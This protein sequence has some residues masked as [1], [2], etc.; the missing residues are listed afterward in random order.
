MASVMGLLE[1][2]EAVA[3]VRVEELQVGLVS[4]QI[5]YWREALADA[6]EELALP[7]D[8]P[9][10]AVA[11]HRSLTAEV[12]VPAEV[13]A[14]LAELARAEGVSLFMV[15]QSAL[16]VLLSRLGAG[17]DVPIGT[18]VAGRTDVA[19]DDLVGFFVNT[20]V[21]RADLSGDPTFRE[22]LDRM[23]ETSLSAFDHQEVPFEKL[24]EELAP[25]RSR[26]RH[27]LFQTV[28]TLQNNA[29]AALDLP[30][31]EASA[32]SAGAPP[33][34]FDLDLVLG[35]TFDVQGAPAGVHGT[36]AGAA[37][38]FEPESVERIAVHFLRVLA[39]V[40]A[41]PQIRLSGV[42]LLDAAERRR[43]LVEWNDTAVAVEPTTLPE[44]FEAQVART[45]DAVAVVADGVEL[46]FA[47]LDARANRLAR[48]LAGRGV[49]PESV[50][51]V[52]LERGTDMLVSLLAVMK[53]G[54]AYL[55]VDPAYPV[56][57]IE[58][59]L[60]DAAPVAVV[61]SR[62]V[63]DTMPSGLPAV[64]LD[65][66]AVLAEL[67][68]LADTSPGVEVLPEHPAYV[69]FTSGSTGRPKGVAVTHSGLANYVSSVPGRVGFDAPGVRYALLQAQ[70]TDL[71]NTVVFASLT[72]GGVLHVIDEGLVTDPSAVSA[73]LAEHGIDCVKIVP[74]HLAALS[75]VVG[76]EGVLPTRSLVLGG[77]AASPA[78]VRELVE[79]AGDRGVFNHYGPTETTIG[80]ATTRLEADGSLVPVGTPVANTR[81]YVLDDA[82]RPVPQGVAGELYVA[83][84]QLAR[85]YVRRPGLTAERFVA[86]P[87]EPGARMYRTGD[88]A[89][90]TADGKVVFLGRADE[91]VKVRGF[92]V[93]PAEV[94]AVIAGHP[95]VAQTVVAAREDVPGDVRLVAYVVPV[96]EAGA[97]E[98]LPNAVREFTARRLPEHMV[99][100]AVVLLDA[101][102]L[103]GNGKLD[104]KALP[105][106]VYATGAGRGPV[107]AREEILCAAFAEVLGLENVGVDDDF[108]RL[109]GHSLLAVHL[110]EVLRKQGV[111]VS[112]R[113]LFDT[114]TPAGLAASAGAE[115]VAVPANLIPAD[116]REITPDMLPLVDLTG[117]EISRIAATVEGGCAN[118]AD[119]YP[120]APLQEGLL[121]HHLMAEGGEDAYLMPVVVEMD[122]RERV[123]D[124]ARA[125]QQV[126]DRHDILR[127]SFVWEGLR[128][129][130]QVVWRRAVLPVTEVALDP[131]AADPVAELQA[132]VG[133]SMDLGRAP[134]ISVHAA[135]LPEGGRWLV[136]LRLHHL[137]QDHTALEV[138]LHEV[139]AFLAG[140]GGELPQ[141]LPFRDFV[142]Q[143][144]G[145]ADRVA[146]ERYF[147]ELLGDVTE[148]TAPYEL[149]DVHGDG[150]AVER[151]VVPLATGLVDRLRSVARRA[152]TSPATLMHVA[153][154]RVLGA[155]S[156]HADVVFGT[157]LFGRMNAGAGADRVAGM[158]LNT[159]PVRLKTGELGALEAVTATRGQLAELL[160]HEHASLALAQ[161]ASGLPGNTPVFTSLLNYRH[162][163]GAEAE[164]QG[165]TVPEGMRV[166]SSS[167]RTNYPLT[168]SVDD[169]GDTMALVVDAVAP[170]A[171]ESVGLLVRTAV[172]GLV[173]LVETAL[174]GA[175]DEALRDVPVLATEE[176]H[177]ILTEWNDA[178][179]ESPGTTLPAL[180]EAQA[181]QTPDAV[182]IV[183]DG[184]RVS[185]AELEA[186]ANRLAR[187]LVS[188]GVGAE[189]VVG[190]CLERGVELI[191]ALLAV[192]KAGGAYLPI[193]PA[194]PADRVAFT[195][196]DA[197][198]ALVLTE[199]GA[200]DRLSG[201]GVDVVALDDPAVAEELALLSAGVL[202]TDERGDLA[203][204]Q[205]AYVIYTSGSTG[206]PKGVVVTHRN[207]TDLFARTQGLFGFGPADV[208]SWF[209]SFAFDFSVW[210]LWGA[211]L[212][213]G[214]VAVVSY[215][216]SR[217]PED[218]VAL[219][220]REGVTMLSQTPS[221]FYQ[222]MGA[223][224]RRPEAVRS[225]RAVVF[226]G[227][228]LD[229]VRLAGWWE[230]HGA[231]GPRLVNMYGITETTVHVTFQELAAG[232]AAGS[233]VGRGI[234]GLGVFVLDERLR[235]VPVGVGGEVYVTGGQLARGY[236]GR[237]GLSA[238]RF[239]ASPFGAA[240]ERMYRTGDRARWGADGLLEYLGRADEQV[241]VRGFRIEPG[242][243]GSVVAEHPGVA[244]AAVVARQD[245][246]D[247]R[248]VAYV[249]PAD[250]HDGDELPSITHEFLTARLPEHMVPSAI[251][252]LDGLPLT[253]NGKLDRKALPAPEYT[254]SAG[255]GP[256]NAREEVLCAAFAEVLGL[257][258]VGVEDNFFQLG[259]HSL[260]AVRLVE[261]L[262][263]HGVSVSVRA[264]FQSPTP[265]GLAASTGATQVEVPANL[266]PADAVEITPEMLPLVELTADEIAGVVAT[267]QGGAA[268]VADVYPLAPL[269]QGLWFHHL[270]AEGGVDA[271]VLP[272]VLEFASRTRL[273]AFVE[274]LQRV[275]DRHDIF[276]TS[277]VWKGLVEP[278]QVVWRKAVLPVAEVALDPQAGDQVEQLLAL[279]GLSVDLGRAPLIDI[280]V[281]AVP[282]GDSWLALMRVHHIVQ[283][284]TAVEVLLREVEAFLTGRGDTLP[285]PLPFRTFV[286]Q[287]RGGVAQ[288]EHER[289][290]ADLLDD[291]E[292]PTA[293]FGLVD[294]RGDGAAAVRR[295]VPFP[296][297]LHER[298]REVSRRLGTSAATVLHVAWA[299]VLAA[300]SSRDDVV[301]GTVLFGRMNSGEGSAQVLGPFINTLPVRVRT[302]ELSVLGA[303]TGMRAQLAD[304]LEH[305]HASLALAQQASGVA[306]DTP[307]FTSFLN[308]RHNTAPSAARASA[309]GLAGIRQVYARERTNY[310]LSVSVNDTGESIALDVDAV[311]PVDPEAVGVLL[312]TATEQLVGALETALATG[313]D[314][315]LNTLP[316]LAEEELRRV[317][318]EWNDTA[319]EV[320][321]VPVVG[322]FEQWAAR[323]PDAVAVVADGEEVSYAELDAR[324]N[325]LA[326]R[327]AGR[328]VGPESVVA[329]ALE[330][331]VDLVV[332]VLA[333]LKSGAAHLP[334]DPEYPAER[335]AFMLEDACPALVL[336][337]AATAEV[338]ERAGTPVLLVDSAEVLRE[339][340]APAERPAALPGQL[341]YVIYTSGSTGR[342]KGVGVPL[343]AFA[344][345]V[346]A[347]ARFG[348]GPGSRVAQFAS[349]SFDNFCLEWS[350]A[351]TYGATLVVVPPNR[352]LGAELAGFFTEAGVTHATLPP[353][354]LAAL[355][356]G[357]IGAEV[358]LEVGGEACPP[359]LVERWAAGRRLFNTYG[360]TETTVD[361]LSWQARPGVTDVPIGA[362][363]AN[364]RAYVLDGAL[365]PVPSGAAGELYLAG[366]GLARGYLGRAG[367]TAERF[368]ADPFGGAG[369]RLYRTGDLVRRNARGEMEYLGRADDQVKVRGF[370]IELGEVRA[371]VAAHPQVLQAAVV[372]RGEE[373]GDALLVAYVV[374]AQG[375]VGLPA[376]V[377]DFVAERLPGYMVPSAVVVLDALPLTVNGK[378]DHRALPAPQYAAG[379]GRGPAT[380]Q[381]E[382]L[383]GV[384]AQ[385][386]GLPEVGVD[387]DFFALGGHSLLATRLMSRIRTV[388][389][390]EVP[391]RTLF[392]APT[393][394]GLAARLGDAGTARTALT[395]GERPERVPLSYGQ[396]RVWFLGQLEG[397]SATYNVPVALRLVGRLEEEALNAALLDV[398]GRHEVLRTVFPVVDDE[399]YQ[400][401]LP[402]EG[403]A[404]RLSVAEVAAEELEPAI[405]EAAAHLFDLASELPI[406]ASLFRTA[407]EEH[408]L[409]VTIHHIASDGWST[410]VLA[411]DLSVAYAAR[412]AGRAPQ[413]QPLPVQYA[414]YALWQRGLLGDEHDP[415]SMISRQA[416]YWRGAL[417][418][419]PEK[420]DLSF[421]R[422]RPAVPSHRGHQV[423]VAVPAEVHARLVELARA[424]GVT[425]FMVLQGA[426]AVLLSR[427]GAGTD[428]PIGSPHAGRTD[429]AL[430]DLVGFFLNTLVV[431][432]DLSGDPTF[433]QVLG[434]VRERSLEAFT[435]QDVPFERLVEE[436]APNRSMAHHALF[437]VMLTLQNTEQAVLELPGLRVEQRRAGRTP[438]R[439]DLDVIV[440]ESF[441]EQGAPAGVRGSVTAA[442]DL[443]DE[444][445]A[446][447]LV[448]RL[449]HVLDVLTGDPQIR[450]STVDVL[451]AAERGRLLEEWNATAADVPSGTVAELFAAQVARDPAAVAV[452]A[453]DDEE[454]TYAELDA[455]ANSLARYLVGRGVG[456]ESIVGVCL[457]RGVDL[458][459]ALLAVAKA[460]GAYL[461]IDP[462]YPV[463]RIAYM[464]EDAEPAV[465]LASSGTAPVVPGSAVLVDA[466]E[467]T[468]AD[469][470]A[471]AAPSVR[472]ENPAYVIYTSGSTGRPKGVLVSH[473]GVASLVAGH[474][475]RLGVGAGSRVGQFASPG[476][477][478]FGWEW[479]MAL[480]TGAT[481]VVIPQERRLGEALPQFLAAERVTHVTLPPAV[482]ATLDEQSIGAD[483]VLVTAGEACPPDVMARWARGHRLFNSYGPTETTVDAT[484]WRCDPQAG[485][486]AIGAPVVNTRVFVLDEFLA[487]VP[488]G[489]PGELYVAG[490]GLA[491][492]YLG[493]PG[494]TA[495][496][497]V[498]NP[499]GGPGERF[500]RTGDRARWT[501]DGQ[502]VFAGRTDDQ[503]K[504]R[505]FRIEPG[506]IENVIASH[507]QVAQAAVVVR[508]DTPAEKRLVAYVVADGAPADLPGLVT[509]LAAERLPEYMVPSAV[510]LL[511]ALPITVNGK[512]DR[513]ALPAPEERPAVG[514]GPAN[515][516]EELLC[517][518]FAQILGVE[519]VGVDDDFF[520]LGGHSLLAVRLASRIRAVLGVN[521]D[522]RVLFDAPTV[523]ALAA[524]IADEDGN[525][526]PALMPMER[527]DRVPLSYAQR[528]MWFIGQLQ[529]A[530]AAYNVP[531]ALK[532]PE[533]IDRQALGAA[534]RDVLGRHEVLR[535]VLPTENGEPHQRIIPL[536][537][538][539]WELSVVEV[540]PK[541][542][543]G[544]VA[545]VAGHVFD[546][547][548]EVPIRAWLLEAG[549][550]ER[551]LAV[552]V[553]H[554]AGDGW[555][556]APLARD[557]SVAYAAR[558]GGRMPLWEP[559]PVQ[560]AD[561]ALWQREL[562][563]EAG[564][565]K[566]LLWRQMEYWRAEL[567]GVPEE[568]ALPVDRVRPAVAS[569]R[570]HEVRVEV[571]AV[572]HAEL[573]RVARAEGVTMFMVLQ[574]ALAVLLSRLGAGADVPIGA[575][576]AGR[577]DAALED[578]VGFFVNTLVIRAD[579]SGDP[580]F[581]EVLGRVRET[582]LSA[583]EHQD[584]PFERL[585]EELA[586][587]R[588]MGRHPLFQTVFTMQNNARA[589]LDLPGTGVSGM[590]TGAATAARFDLDVL[591]GEAF[592][593]Q[594]APAGVF[595]T[596]IG[597]ADLFEAESV[598]RIAE[599]LVRVL[600]LVAGDPGLRLSGVDVLEETERRRVLA[601]WNDTGVDFGA[602][603]VPELFAVQAVRTPD[604][605]AV[606]ADG[607]EVSYRELDERANRLAHY[608]LAQGVGAESL[609]GICLPRGVDMMVALLATWKAGAGYL[610]VD[611]E[612]PAERIAFM[613]AD[614][615]AVLTLTDEEVLDELPA[616]RARVVA[617]DGAL[618]ATQVAALPTTAPGVPVSADGLAYVIYT[619]GSTGRPKGV[620]VTHGGL[621]NYARHAAGSYGAEGGA[622]LHS[623]LAF[624][625]T[626]TSVVVPLISGAPVVV[627]REGG[628]EGLAQLLRD[629]GGFGLVKAVPAHLPLLGEMLSDGQAKGAAA[630]WVVGGEALPAAVVRSWLE[631]AP[632]SVVVNEYGPTET[633]VGC[634]VFALRA[635]QEMGEPVPVGRPIA[636]TRLYVLDAYLRP[637]A[638]G[639]A[640]ELYIAGTQLARGYVKRP[641][642]TAER[643]VANPFEPALRMYR[644]GDVA[645]WRTDGQL[646]YLGRADEQV[647][648]RGFRIEPGE[649]QAVLAAHPQVA[650]A[651]VI[652]RQDVPGDTRLVA[653]VVAD[654][655][656]GGLP[657][658]VLAF[659]AK[660]LPEY[661]VPS[662]V[663][664]LDALPLTGNGK[665]DRKALPV[666]DYAAG[667][668]AGRAPANPQEQLLCQAF[669]AVLGLEKVGVDDDFFELGGH[670]L[671][672]VELVARIRAV[673]EVEV[674]IRTLFD[675]PT[676]AGLAQRLG[677]EKSS[678][679][680]LRP[681]RDRDAR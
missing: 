80:V 278:V 210:E 193:D 95:L 651:A 127:T 510:V 585:V 458:M 634:A 152:G 177:R 225:L 451:D 680:A 394:A 45:P 124:F 233:V 443:L 139:R 187:S 501:A 562:L 659:A 73:H 616:G 268:N 580:S 584:V 250:G 3:R 352:R 19:L 367:L 389:G 44:L 563:G 16:A 676:V 96:G 157:V 311:A 495:E 494:L 174:D 523:A 416:D 533:Q 505:G 518:V 69:I 321:P 255:R 546:L 154:A 355:E 600:E 547:A 223:E 537:E 13:H 138:L 144:R 579:L 305:E 153:W 507:P 432:T 467:T 320:S 328:G 17:T 26:G 310:P 240:G 273:D 524:R 185:Y 639:V 556:W 592:D 92:R 461:P 561:Y 438:A 104:R 284:H 77:E 190:V 271:Y 516:R 58:I 339:P 281:A 161:Q 279:A 48:L 79:H 629:G 434:R 377:R 514:R 146:H 123:E 557:L 149:V 257:E 593:A 374:A 76:V 571:P 207:V 454:V 455:R 482:L 182:A 390:V 117:E 206:R 402:A 500:Y 330:R 424:E 280:H 179:A 136:L 103:T 102:P 237:A 337:S 423:P 387:D 378:L 532:L 654:D 37:D 493:R 91:Q 391:L 658:T 267:V 512:L 309:D 601:E 159:L 578:L 403:P 236:L 604:A 232:D 286:A 409:V 100:S 166:L 376:S 526:R 633:V 596:V 667:A 628:A 186:R 385:V 133:L 8:R 241:K 570:G 400:R 545:E 608:L 68:G 168:V 30:G 446:E 256:A 657:D 528:R 111:S 508:E 285:E 626:V 671:L 614:S 306:G 67:A 180:F 258:S 519:S 35:E 360:P 253:I 426:L 120:L 300:V 488:V 46:S 303:V 263:G 361:A 340:A 652:A 61:T 353:A 612:Y 471:L 274:A 183:A 502:L 641:G 55:P 408:V 170:I 323:T 410:G 631:R 199:Q 363:I 459:V 325:R 171:P 407:P 365:S 78:L 440:S 176:L 346:A 553:H 606:R 498:A 6:P 362:P 560:Y 135:A 383:C 406:R 11:S 531:M 293:P 632:E 47:D 126:V 338:V 198:A 567:A 121:F 49:G 7:V 248:L 480:L 134:L 276:R 414:D 341:A 229:P 370:R 125:F 552:V 369:E 540:A 220:E 356:E 34:R 603:L 94:Q 209:H 359:E 348:A 62:T 316:V 178:G 114:P 349:V 167:E 384:F 165:D 638:P 234:P 15:L 196:D 357:S 673:L 479:L 397:P 189:S 106:P 456:A 116:A 212:H 112:V 307:L 22:V 155:V 314:Q 224:E 460:G 119:V 617:V 322:Q 5:G 646:E 568:L 299:R 101:L 93:E 313:A 605:V 415:E 637:V 509:R 572:L 283:D 425:V 324:A 296:P 594:G 650:Q 33:V 466:P 282:E 489:V 251:V 481:L 643:F 217:S 668:G 90:W 97:A 287:A 624:D 485:E 504:I 57:R 259:G 84:A 538:L 85:G 588:S 51:A 666:P 645:R 109:G 205:P 590:P 329:L 156:G 625:L 618:T 158:Y 195:I 249:V 609:V 315:R 150:A 42:E 453:A 483:T 354:V 27:P 50:V 204:D 396:R 188:R 463:D 417:A 569:N 312:R 615:G 474:V 515:P 583:F 52:A 476:F 544:A 331:G 108:F 227:E 669:A 664:V 636:N 382:L 302:G 364:T 107:N 129:P 231:D 181:A 226:G 59:A 21:I 662:A 555:S 318:T 468:A 517:G 587:A 86:H 527:P 83:G 238:E 550:R 478:T 12:A 164:Q 457:E 677:T 398:I 442:A 243:I 475:R 87:F 496:R 43:V 436:L 530:G 536:E 465:V 294:V 163:T 63:A 619:S 269:Q 242:E 319:T 191:V 89:R 441:D 208:W 647:K 404:W 130:V 98:A 401:V 230:R 143:V 25:T 520:A 216:V 252:V 371:A 534:L 336:A 147:A 661:M 131:E 105:A 419:A 60:A 88:R 31:L 499:F 137:V 264:F 151:A 595:G 347:L 541:E 539:E 395:A 591:L 670:S 492:G 99:P 214:R 665:L 484:L 66:P 462:A 148:P 433:R 222:F 350:L 422:P 554:I 23:R 308:Y 529:D 375:T 228:A 586:P 351:L 368:V 71:G 469:G 627:S 655:E 452:V 635:G 428:I 10:P 576:N 40:A 53:A 607:E 342:P 289:Y 132:V 630:T 115:E 573:A 521:L 194:Y 445:S 672:A 681:M 598:E 564:D 75:S 291:V 487:P 543:E 642:L 610:P 582:S 405:A 430:S 110:V 145:S 477:D 506:E 29:E 36:V 644:S 81:F 72:T 366:A 333:V 611:P 490:I 266:I 270:M 472:L 261:V 344:N 213:G 413:W 559:L 141:P 565:P 39:A 245:A 332:A 260:L 450:L 9:R 211:L 566:S 2:R 277:I 20:L 656:V 215:E 65:E 345:T 172:E 203:P 522:I 128:E 503:V 675:A 173:P 470:G 674:P 558:A 28:L 295:M 1:E 304:L 491:R 589:V 122:S 373:V 388:L 343:A 288:A 327:L 246:G 169:N 418:G 392:D 372:V 272:T 393:V 82:L 4:R 599:R 620:A 473:T 118:I 497:F 678:R 437:Q 648:V 160:E 379:T 244:Q 32:L 200:A 577:T 380:L 298:L 334:V 18:V 219:V 448:A 218:F 292:E 175:P 335:I 548:V 542:L 551:V 24:V 41:D 197:K 439:F 429:D 574:S 192:V 290:F 265:A 427:L 449:V 301:F 613:L 464:L 358:V 64:V 202:S 623:S 649:V 621:A 602:A 56:D 549:P 113:A 653:Y 399:P 38:L 535:T 297:E 420:L 444:A 640:G 679:P 14:R 411:R 513:K 435:H 622:P 412:T 162:N 140:R 431:R 54:G 201:L 317:L 184:E 581:R 663:V 386:L 239:V 597:A 525:D 275:V 74:S 235:P 142:A 486:V 254:A 326:H 511:D 381:E 421:D 262:R 247:T 447:R 660:R 70:V 575:A 221:A